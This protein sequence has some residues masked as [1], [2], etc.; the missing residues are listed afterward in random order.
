MYGDQSGE[1]LRG[2]RDLKGEKELS[3]ISFSAIFDHFFPLFVWKRVLN[4]T[5]A[6]KLGSYCG[7]ECSLLYKNTWAEL[8]KAD[9]K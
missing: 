7:R 6:F 5:L 1:F 4:C 8:F 2:Y 9:L 3:V